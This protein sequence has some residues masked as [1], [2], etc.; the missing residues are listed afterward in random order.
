M[1]ADNKNAIAKL[2]RERWLE[3]ALEVLKESGG[4][5]DIET[6]CR[7]LGV[8]KGSFYWHFSDRREFRLD[9]VSFWDEGY[10]ET[11][12]GE[13][14]ALEATPAEKFAALFEMVIKRDLDR[15]E[16]AMHAWAL[17]DPEVAAAVQG[18]WLQ[19]RDF[20][21]E[22][23]QSGGYSRADANRLGRILLGY[24]M[25]DAEFSPGESPRERIS[26]ARKVIA[27]LLE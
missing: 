10:T 22:I 23:L 3:N 14:S 8:S 6:L 25:T 20:F 21:S 12:I 19:R 15:L 4:Q 1:K 9:V 7:R 27:Q 16:E 24:I 26:R 18:V 5:L 2:S 11:V 13:I 17:R